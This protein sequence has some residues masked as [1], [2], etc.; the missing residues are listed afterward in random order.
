[1]KKLLKIA[2]NFTAK[3]FSQYVWSG[4]ALMFLLAV[5]AALFF[6]IPPKKESSLNDDPGHRHI[7][8]AIG[9]FGEYDAS[10]SGGYSASPR[11]D[12]Y[13]STDVTGITQTNDFGSIDGT[14]AP[15]IQFLVCQ[16]D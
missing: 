14:N 16:K 6:E 15:Y 9:Q 2:N 10:Q 3:L 13:T 12:E 7:R 1:M 4:I 8:W 11:T 5:S